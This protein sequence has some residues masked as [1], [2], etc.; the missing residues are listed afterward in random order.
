MALPPLLNGAV[1]LST[2]CPSPALAVNA[3]GADGTVAGVAVVVAFAPL[4]TA[5]TAR[6][7]K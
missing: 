4:P 5:L 2:T 6:T 1:Q 3:C 7:A